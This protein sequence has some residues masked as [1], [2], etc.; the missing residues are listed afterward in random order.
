MSGLGSE[1]GAAELCTGRSA[2]RGVA[3]DS[4]EVQATGNF[5]YA[6]HFSIDGVP[7]G[8]WPDADTAPRMSPSDARLA[9]LRPLS[10]RGDFFEGRPILD[11]LGSP[12]GALKNRVYVCADEY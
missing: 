2:P 1:R 4:V 7:A 11:S 5:S 3:G 8:R 9:G 10:W 6:D 12:P